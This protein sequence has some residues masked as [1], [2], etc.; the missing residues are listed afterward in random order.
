MLL[1]LIHKFRLNIHIFIY[2][3][4]VWGHI[5][6]SLYLYKKTFGRSRDLR[7]IILLL[8]L[9]YSSENLDRRQKDLK[10][11]FSLH[12]S[13]G[14]KNFVDLFWA[15]YFWKYIWWERD[16]RIFSEPDSKGWNTPTKKESL[17]ASFPVFFMAVKIFL[18]RQVVD[19]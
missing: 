9:S 7:K 17:P 10:S 3:S 5:W 2:L 11:I 14:F 15:Q 8:I 18:S 19:V 4:F 16:K 6:I 13:L 1:I 12:G